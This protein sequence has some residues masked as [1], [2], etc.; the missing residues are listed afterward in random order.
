M[1]VHFQKPLLLLFLKTEVTSLTFPFLKMG[2]SL[3]L[4]LHWQINQFTTQLQQRPSSSQEQNG[5][6]KRII[7]AEKEQGP[8]ITPGPVKIPS[9]EPLQISCIIFLFHCQVK[10][11]VIQ[12]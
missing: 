2:M 8:E 5:C 1:T 9:R 7:R 3:S 6:S 11:Y 12:V 10:W 4:P